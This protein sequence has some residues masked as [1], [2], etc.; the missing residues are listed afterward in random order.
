MVCAAPTLLRFVP[1][2]A[3][4]AVLVYCGFKLINFKV[5]RALWKQGPGEVL[6]YGVTVAAVVATDLLTGVAI[7]LSLSGLRVLY[8]LSHLEIQLSVCKIH[9]HDVLRLSGTATFVRLPQLA[10]VLENS[11][12]TRQMRVDLSGLHF[13]DDA[14]RQLLTDWERQQVAA[15]RSVTVHRSGNRPAACW[16]QPFRDEYSENSAIVNAW[17]STKST[18]PEINASGDQR[19]PCSLPIHPAGR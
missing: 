1:S 4:A 7:G 13:I 19:A 15:G 12:S 18:R 2:S 11:T 5:I 10:S 14:C 6:V 3:L 16:C 17:R 9:G 8:T